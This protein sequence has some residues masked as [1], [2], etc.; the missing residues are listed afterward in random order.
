[1]FDKILMANR[2]EIACRVMETARRDWG[3]A[4]W[5]SIPT[6]MRRAP[7]GDGR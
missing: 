2:G 1:M 5:R 3:S 7:C 6:R 4:R